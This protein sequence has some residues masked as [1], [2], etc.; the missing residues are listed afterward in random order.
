MME[1]EDQYYTLCWLDD[2]SL[3]VVHQQYIG[4]PFDSIQLHQLYFINIHGRHCQATVL[5]KGI[6]NLVLF[7]DDQ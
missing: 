5:H 3:Q 2:D 1:N 6:T 4:V 7:R